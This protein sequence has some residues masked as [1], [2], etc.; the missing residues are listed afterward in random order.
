[1]EGGSVVPSIT[2]CL[3]AVRCVPEKFFAEIEMVTSRAKVHVLQWDHAFQGYS[4]YRRGDW[5]KIEVRGRGGTDMA[6]P[7]DWLEERRAVGDACI[8][9]TDGICNWPSE[10]K[11]PFIVVIAGDNKGYGYKDPPWGKVVRIEA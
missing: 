9:L 10:R 8:M 2:F 5:K 3:S 6:A 4:R 1:M 11:F 7:V